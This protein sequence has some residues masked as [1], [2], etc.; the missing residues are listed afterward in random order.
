MTVRAIRFGCEIRS[1]PVGVV[2]SPTF[3]IHQAGPHA[4]GTIVICGV[5]ALNLLLNLILDQIKQLDEPQ[6]TIDR[7]APFQS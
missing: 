2:P 1:G 5:I 6:G 7:D 4:M 3:D